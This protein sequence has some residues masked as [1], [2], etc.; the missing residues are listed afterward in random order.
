MGRRIVTVFSN[1]ARDGHRDGPRHRGRVAS[2]G[3]WFAV[4]TGLLSMSLTFFLTNDAFYFDILPILSLAR[5]NLADPTRR[6]SGD[7]WSAHW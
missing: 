3:P 7:P 4:I 5:V 6:S 1:D 2:L